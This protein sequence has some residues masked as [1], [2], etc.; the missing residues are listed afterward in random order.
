MDFAGKLA[1][2]STM[3]PTALPAKDLLRMAT[4]EGARAMKMDDRIGS[5]E[6]GKRADLV[7]VDLSGARTQPLWD[8]FS[9]LVYAVK[10]SD[11]SLTMVEGRVLWDGRTRADRRRGEER[12]AKRKSGGK[13]SRPR[14]R[15][16]LAK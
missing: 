7:A 14:S 1:K 10:E 15:S 11:V 6:P 3:D 5:L 2:V 9:T 12:C 16:R 13:R 4:I 8:V